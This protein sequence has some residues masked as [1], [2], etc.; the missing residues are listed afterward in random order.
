MFRRGAPVVY[1]LTKSSIKPGPRAQ[2]VDPAPRGDSYSYLVEKY[3]VVRDV[4]PD[5]RLLLAT[6]RGK[7]HTID[8]DDPNLRHARW[9]ERIVYRSRFPDPAVVRN[10]SPAPEAAPVTPKQRTA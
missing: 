3:W 9:W 7:E 5:G 6:R 2:R 4:L 1:R 10:V 8:S